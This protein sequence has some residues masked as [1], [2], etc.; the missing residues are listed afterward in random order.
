MELTNIP[1]YGF[2]ATFM[3]PQVTVVSPL[4]FQSN[5]S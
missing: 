2:W 3:A 5:T 1:S 4:L